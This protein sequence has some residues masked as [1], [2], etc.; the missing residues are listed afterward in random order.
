MGQMNLPAD[1]GSVTWVPLHVTALAA[2]AEQDEGMT[3]RARKLR[4]RAE[5]CPTN[6]AARGVAEE[7]LLRLGAALRA[8]ATELKSFYESII[9]E[10]RSVLFERERLRLQRLLKALEAPL[11]VRPPIK[12][13]PVNTS[14][15]LSAQGL[16]ALLW[17][18]T[19]GA[20]ATVHS[21]PS[22]PKGTSRRHQSFA[23]PPDAPPVLQLPAKPAL[24]LHSLRGTP[25]F[26]T[27]PT[28]PR[29]GMKSPRGAMSPRT[30]SPPASSLRPAALGPNYVPSPLQG[31]A[32]PEPPSPPAAPSGRSH[33]KKRSFALPD[34]AFSLDATSPEDSPGELTGVPG[35][36]ESSSLEQGNLEP[37]TPIEPLE[38]PSNKSKESDP[39]RVVELVVKLTA[40]E[41]EE[42]MRLAR[43]RTRE[44]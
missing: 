4:D 16:G 21:A 44:V 8:R 13:L 19:G 38:E 20:L 23:A 2:V 35:T 17:K 1:N 14:D 15:T 43:Q 11:A 39:G 32:F 42:L 3:I 6:S 31:V 41:F 29:S 37:G 18:K 24:R 36:T 28:S 22:T 12:P 26:Q 30:G 25:P 34:D 9:L 40:D 7:A 27:G 33:S 10:D 5:R